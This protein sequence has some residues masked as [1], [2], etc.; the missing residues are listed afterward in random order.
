[1]AAEAKLESSTKELTTT[2]T[3]PEIGLP[4]VSGRFT[5]CPGEYIFSAHAEAMLDT[6]GICTEPISEEGG[7]R[8]HHEGFALASFEMRVIEELASCR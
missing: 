6:I 2:A 4:P 3:Y 8:D 1:M 7:R 5:L